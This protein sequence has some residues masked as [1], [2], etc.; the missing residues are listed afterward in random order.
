[1]T[2]G[3]MRSGGLL[4]HS[5]HHHHHLPDAPDDHRCV[6]AVIAFLGSK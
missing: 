5:H 2:A 6:L 4:E 1:M 3:L